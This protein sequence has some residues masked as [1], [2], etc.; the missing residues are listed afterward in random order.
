MHDARQ[1]DEICIMICAWCHER[2]LSKVKKQLCIGDGMDGEHQMYRKQLMHQILDLI[3]TFIS[4]SHYHS[5]CPFFANLKYHSN[6]YGMF[7]KFYT[8]FFYILF[9]FIFTLSN[10]LFFT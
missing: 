9:A 1:D 10:Y 3:S 7:V 6:L 2:C 8:T 4:A 5:S